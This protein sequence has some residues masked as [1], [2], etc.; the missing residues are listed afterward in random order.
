MTEQNS[1]TNMD[2]AITIDQKHLLAL[3]RSIMYINVCKKSLFKGIHNINLLAFVIDS[4]FTQISVV[5]F[6]LLYY[7][8]AATTGVLRFF[9]KNF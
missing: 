2:D 3:R 7:E 1:N 5:V 6:C 9:F 8:T 4:I